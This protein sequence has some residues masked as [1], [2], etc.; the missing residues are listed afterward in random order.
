MNSSTSNWQRQPADPQPDEDPRLVR[1]AQDYLA[2]VEAGR[3]PDRKE[4]AAQHADLFP[5]LAPY[6][7]AL[8]LLHAPPPAPPAPE[9]ALEPTALGDFRIVREI[10]RGGMGVVYEAVQL[11]LGRRVALKVLPFAATLDAKQLQRFKNEAQAAAQLHH[12]NIVPVYGVGAERGVHYYAMQ[13]IEGQ[14]LSD[15]IRDL[16]RQKQDARRGDLL[17]GGGTAIDGTARD[18]QTAATPAT[19]PEMAAGLTTRRATRSASFYQTAVRLVVQAADALEHAHQLGVIHRDVKPANLLVD[20]RGCPWVTDFGLAQ[21]HTGVGLTRTGDLMGTLRYM[22]PEQAS[23]QRVAVDARTDVY[24]LGATLYELL[25]LEPLF[26]GADHPTL[27]R[28]ILQDEPR[29][30]RAVER[31]VPAELETIVLKAVAKSPADRYATAQEFADDLHRYLENKPIQAR[32]PTLSQRVRKWAQRHPAVVVATGVVL[33]LVSG[34]SLGSAALVMGEQAKTEA[35][36]KAERLRAD[37]AESRLSLA[38][39]AVDELKKVSEEELANRPGNERLRKRVLESVLAYYREFIDQRRDDPTA[40][41]ELRDTEKQIEQI[42]ADLLVLEANGRLDLLSQSSVLKDLDLTDKQEKQVKKLTDRLDKQRGDIW[43]GDVSRL[44][45]DQKRQWF[46][47][48]ARANDTEVKTIL[49]DRQLARL[50]QIALQQQ[51][52]GAF[53]EPDIAVALK[54]LPK[55]R[56]RI[57]AIDEEAF[58]SG[59]RDWGRPG[60]PSKEMREANEQKRKKAL[61]DVLALLTPEQTRL[62]KQMSGEPFTGPLPM[63]PPF[64]P[65]GPPP[66]PGGPGGGPGGKPKASPPGPESHR[67]D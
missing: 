34:V 17:A 2:A 64:F 23:G 56:D 65:G 18:P 52:A 25:T 61:E 16:R 48:Q 4:F 10:G 29:S 38:Q 13:L 9:P 32:R 46:L 28:Q 5:A 40:Q 43:F 37:E 26:D 45:S 22:S 35:A 58:F 20:V 41:K 8:D 53:R 51:G 36:Y 60:G 39:R 62:W 1:A 14:N 55:Q 66:G 42:V 47:D 50:P 54:L 30:P 21:F 57:R 27:L 63:F 59:M 24:S 49:D 12:T 11:S 31:S 44:P 6:L 3:R 15:L 7:D 19:F 33:L 67:N